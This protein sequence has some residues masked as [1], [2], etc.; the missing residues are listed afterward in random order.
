MPSKTE[1]KQPAKGKPASTKKPA[2]KKPA[3]Q[4]KV[5]VGITEL[6]ADLGRD[7]R[8]VRAS[9]RRMKGGA[10]VGRG[11]RYSWKSKSDP[12]YK[13]ML[14]DLQAPTTSKTSKKEE[15]AVVEDEDA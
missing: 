9:I 7:P 5:G 1:T 2:A 8:S 12:K 11:G 14:K 3:T 13:A 10:Q 15:D 6:A 4:D